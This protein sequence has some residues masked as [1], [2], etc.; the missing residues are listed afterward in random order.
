MDTLWLG[1]KVMVCFLIV[2]HSFYTLGDFFINSRARSEKPM[3]YY[4]YFRFIMAL[5]IWSYLIG[6]LLKGAGA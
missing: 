1:M 3:R 6:L 5:L 2:G 4:Y